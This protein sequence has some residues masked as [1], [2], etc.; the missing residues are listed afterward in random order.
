MPGIYVAPCTFLTVSYKEN[1]L[2]LPAKVRKIETNNISTDVLQTQCISN[3]QY[4]AV[5]Y[6]YIGP[7]Y[8]TVLSFE[9][10]MI[11]TVKLFYDSVLHYRMSSVT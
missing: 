11:L 7:L 2:L 10:I 9:S 6:V 4:I 8:I 5:L 3:C 1:A